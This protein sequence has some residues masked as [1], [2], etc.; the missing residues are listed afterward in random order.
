MI[1]RVEV[2]S[3]VHIYHPFDRLPLFSDLFQGCVWGSSW[4]ESMRT[5]LKD[6]FIDPFQDDPHHLLDQF[7]VS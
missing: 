3:D 6:W 2:I 4:S 7:V 5:V 1:D